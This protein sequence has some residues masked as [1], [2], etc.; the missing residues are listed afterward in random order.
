[1][2]RAARTA[3]LA[4]SLTG[5]AMS[6]IALLPGSAYAD[7]TSSGVPADR[8]NYIALACTATGAGTN[9]DPY[10]AY[11]TAFSGQPPAQ[12]G[13]DIHV[14][15]NPDQPTYE[16]FARVELEAIPAGAGI[17]SLKVTFH[18]TDDQVRQQENVNVGT[19]NTNCVEGTSTCNP[20][21]NDGILDA[22]PLKSAYPAKWDANR[23]PAY[24]TS[25]PE[26]VAT[27][28][29]K[30]ASW[31]F[32]LAPMVPY[33]QQH[34]NT[35][36]AI[37][38]DA[39]A[40]TEPW[41]VGFQMSSTE[42]EAEYVL[43]TASTSTFQSTLFQP[44]TTSGA[45]SQPA[46]SLSLSPRAPALGANAPPQPSQAATRPVSAAPAAVPVAPKGWVPIW[47][48]VLGVSA[49]AAVALLAQPVSAA[50]ATAGGA[51]AALVGQLRLHPRLFAVAGALL[52]W[53]S[54]FS[55]YANTLGRTSLNPAATSRAQNGGGSASGSQV[56]AAGA[57]ATPSAG[58]A[59][60]SAGS[61]G[62]GGAS[63]AQQYPNSPNP[64]SASLFTPDQERVGLTDSTIAMCAHAA[65]TF[66]PA[67]NIGASDLNV[68][69]QGVDDSGGIWGRKV[70]QANDHTQP[71]IEVTD[72]G[73]QPSKAVTAEAK[74]RDDGTFFLLGGIGFDQI[75]AVR[76]WAEQNHMLYIHHIA[77]ETGADGLRYSFTMLPSLEVVGKQYA[78][79]Y[80]SKY[81]GKR[82][83]IIER[84]SS[85]WEAGANVFKQTL[86]DAGY[87]SD[88]VA[89]EYVQNNQG[90]YSQQIADLSTV[91]HADVVLIWEN[92]LAAEQ[93]IQQSD[94]QSYHPYWIGF[95][96]NL[97]LQT[98]AQAGMATTNLQKYSGMVPWPAYTCYAG[99]LPQFAPYSQEIKQFEAA[100][101]KYDPNAKLCG[102]G[103]DLLFGTWLAWRQVYDLLYQCG[104]DC[105]R[106]KIA[107]LMLSGYHAQVGANCPVDFSTGDHHHGGYGE[108]V[109]QVETLHTSGPSG[110]YSGP[111]WVTVMPMCRRDIS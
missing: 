15:A 41:Q 72:D 106:D 6:V 73:Y 26:A 1:M 77:L 30:D 25:A 50:L 98:L 19:G 75:P 109:Y 29:P 83:G 59:G 24:D 47:T 2:R 9:C 14:G 66:G 101:L 93:I 10:T 38:P 80:V 34:G 35:G 69:W 12:D 16:S 86:Q 107:G 53:S 84:N 110:S 108:D 105:T 97:T 103:G 49:A 44:S 18:P 76:I 70:V 65:L 87:G 3:L 104:R 45:A 39:A 4:L 20:Q 13:I 89:D 5:L 58:S 82:I 56:A 21:P 32:E 28:N 78:Q 68:F 74:C 60:V 7:T 64:P 99:D 52:V 36:F 91:K 71:G 63:A 8:Q 48:L 33:W 23:A 17:S 51:G 100:Y 96:F 22:Y 79:Y 62:S 111:A 88:I 31:T 95:P 42:G 90:Q 54:T 57:G 94:Q 40:T 37:V 92:A 55:V 61:A 85:N 46:L 81:A 27:F 11:Q 43:T 102:F 67:F